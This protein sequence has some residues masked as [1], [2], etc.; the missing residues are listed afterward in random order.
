M[1]HRHFHAEEAVS[2]PILVSLT[3]HVDPNRIYLLAVGL[4]MI[5]KAD[6]A[7]LADGFPFACAFRVL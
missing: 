3:S 1:G 6:L 7:Y 5:A 2:V 4:I